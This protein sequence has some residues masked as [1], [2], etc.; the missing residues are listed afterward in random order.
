M[1]QEI[2]LETKETAIPGRL[3]I[4]FVIRGYFLHSVIIQTDD[5]FIII[6]GPDCPISK[7]RQF[8]HEFFPC[9]TPLIG[10]E[11]GH[12]IRASTG[13]EKRIAEKIGPEGEGFYCFFV[14]WIEGSPVAGMFFRPEEVHA[15]SAIR[16]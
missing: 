12:K 14:V 4:T 5:L 8:G 1:M 2:F 9:F 10:S 15:C 6:D 7:S 13:A 11:P 16:P 3:A